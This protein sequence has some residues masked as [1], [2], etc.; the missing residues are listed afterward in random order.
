MCNMFYL[1]NDSSVMVAPTGVAAQNCH[2]STPERAL[3][4]ASRS[5]TK[6][7]PPTTNKLGKLQEKHAHVRC[8]LVDEMSMVGKCFMGQLAKAAANVFNQGE[9]T[10]EVGAPLPLWGGLPIVLFFGDFCQ[11][12][13]VMDPGV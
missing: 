4:M 3:G 11:L 13:P 1:V 8:L 10:A 12:P 5:S 6:F 9:F 2:G 7:L